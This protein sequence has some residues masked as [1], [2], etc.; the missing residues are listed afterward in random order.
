MENI[1]DLIDEI[2]NQ[3][4]VRES[5]QPTRQDDLTRTRLVKIDVSF[6]DL[7]CFLVKLAIAAVPAAIIVFIF[8]TLLGVLFGY[9]VGALVRPFNHF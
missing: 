6:F 1:F 8:W 2:P 7:V 3:D 9:G 5:A 4:K